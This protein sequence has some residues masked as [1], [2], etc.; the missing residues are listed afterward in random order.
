[1]SKIIK[2]YNNLY[3]NKRDS[4]SSDSENDSDYETIDDESS[5]SSSSDTSS[6]DIEQD[7]DEEEEL[8]FNESSDEEESAAADLKKKKRRSEGSDS[9]GKRRMKRIIVDSD[10]SEDE[11]PPPS[12]SSKKNRTKKSKSAAAADSSGASVNS[13]K[14]NHSKKSKKSKKSK[15]SRRSDE[16]DE[17]EKSSGEDEDT[18]EGETDENEDVS[19]SHVL[20]RGKSSSSSAQNIPLIIINSTPAGDEGDDFFEEDEFYHDT[21]NEDYTS[22]DERNFMKENYEKVAEPEIMKKKNSKKEAK[23][24]SSKHRTSESSASSEEKSATAKKSAEEKRDVREEYKQLLELKKHLTENLRIS[25]NSKVLQNAIRD[26]KKEI[27]KLIKTTRNENTNHYI[28]LLKKGTQQNTSEIEFFKKKL[29]NKEQL[30]VMDELNEINNHIFVE[31][32]YR[33]ALLETQIPAR[34]KSIAYQKL[35]VLKSMDPGENEYYKIKN[36]VDTF[37]RIPFGIYR[38]LNVSISDGIDVCHDFI[39]RAKDTLDNCVYGHSDAKMQILQMAGQWIS[40]P[41]SL[42]TAIAIKGPAGTGKTT[43]I[44]DGISK[45]FGREFAFIPLGGATDSSY[46]EGHSY[47]Y[48]GS[49]W[50]R[51]VQILVDG[52]TMNPVIFFDELDKVSDT[53]RGEEIINV[54]MHLTDTTQNSQFHD[55]YFSEIHFDLSK[56]LFIFSYNDESKISPI[57]RDRMYAIHTKGYELKDK[58]IIARQH[59]LPK[60]RE[61]VN[62]TEEEVTIPD[63]VISY[64]ISNQEFTKNEEG[65]RNLK[66]CLETIYTKL[67]LYRLVKP[68]TD[69]LQKDINLEVTFPYTVTRATVDKLIRNTDRTQN[70][71]MLAMYV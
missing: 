18:R 31:K 12:S 60:I 24:K 69:L 58:L 29:S 57:L 52:K 9:A 71:S 67:N 27:K 2:K 16:D 56:C 40:N 25:P 39:A 63:D 5:S 4:S 65:V 20:Y 64:I 62:F 35:N 46:L 38:T 45:I 10:S 19:D 22:E 33:L 61:Q 59:L 1:M 37:M 26:C 55:K 53:P 51:I 14:K 17:S 66:R 42:G 47:T 68:G 15:S 11:S 48:E 44:K 34:F 23:K 28:K 36:W 21:K 8:L 54:L 13:S 30:K 43:I 70:Q 3:S 50:G 7:E 6:S 41:A 49:Q 32:P